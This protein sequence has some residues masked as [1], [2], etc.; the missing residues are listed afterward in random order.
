MSSFPASIATLTGNGV[1]IGTLQTKATNDATYDHAT[2]HYQ[3][4]DEIEAI[5]TFL[6]TGGSAPAANQVLIGSGTGTSAWSGAPTLT[7]IETSAA[8]TIGTNASIGGT[9]TVTGNTALNGTGNT[10]ASADFTGATR[11]SNAT[12]HQF[13]NSS[14][15]LDA[16]IQ[17]DAN[18]DLIIDSTNEIKFQINNE[19]DIVSMDD[20]MGGWLP[21]QET[22]TF[23]SDDDPTYV[24]T[25]ASDVTARFKAGTRVKLT[26]SGTQYFVVSK[27]ST[28]AAGTT[29]IT[30]YGG[31]S[32]AQ[33]ALSGGAITGVYY[34]YAKCPPGFS[35]KKSDWTE[36]TTDSNNTAQTP[37][38]AGT[39]YNLNSISIDIPIGCW[40]VDYDVPVYI[41]DAAATQN[42]ISDVNATLST[43]NNSET[44]TDF[45][46]VD[47]VK[48]YLSATTSYR[49]A[50]LHKEGEI[51]ITT[52]DTYYLNVKTD[53]ANISQMGV[54]GTDVPIRIRARFA[55]L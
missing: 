54:V 42:L 11:I 28:E 10:L 16:S 9:L 5:E 51:D 21:I 35:I 45:S 19:A 30:M 40:D 39:W 41:F 43:T 14:N 22:F 8:A 29:T 31:T 25:V 1:A 26:D 46:A 44:D 47:Y 7:S 37:P 55:Y 32:H 2:M 4:A 38:V 3:N 33:G 52:K 53:E 13:E 15:A 17:E 27:D 6:G 50:Q 24:V 18:D 34:S 23:S 49:V 20:I 36:T 48:A 12:K